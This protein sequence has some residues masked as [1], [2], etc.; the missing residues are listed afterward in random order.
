M[1][2]G[3][4]LR[5]LKVLFVDD[6]KNI[7]SSL[8]RL[9]VDEEFET[10]TASSG[11]EGLELLRAEENIG[12]VVSDQRMP[13]M[14]GAE[15]L[16]EVR[17]LCPDIPR[18]V[19][20][21]YADIDAAMDAINKGGACR[22]IKKPWD[23]DELLQ[24]LR[25]E[26]QRYRLLLENRQLQEVIRQKNEE[27][28][29]WNRNLKKRVLEQT[30]EIRVRNEQLHEQN[31]ELQRTLHGTIE[32]LSTLVELRDR[33]SAGHSVNVAHVSEAIAR[34]LGL[35]EEDVQ[36]IVEAA[37]LHDIGKIGIP[38]RL[39]GQ[40]PDEMT[41][42]DRAAY[43]KHAILGQLA[44]DKIVRLRP[45]GELVRHHHEWYDGSGYP[46]RL[47]GER[48][49]LGARIIA[50]ADYADHNLGKKADLDNIK[51]VLLRIEEQC[52]DRFD[53]YL[54]PHLRQPVI[55]LYGKLVCAGDK[56]GAILEPRELRVG[57]VLAENLY[58]GTGLM[59]L[60][61]GTVLEKKHLDSIMRYHMIDPFPGGVTVLVDRLEQSAAMDAD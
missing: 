53:P 40:D 25:G 2:D 42:D 29:E 32:A 54:F 34:G 19:L 44:I 13:E 18:I 11:A 61:E 49:P 57:M 35:G 38:G 16:A 9:T 27:L 23:N 55:E 51:K 26:L 58:S 30:R 22:Y 36:I 17:R 47:A 56:V 43:L 14:T 12:L 48:I 59:L 8:R 3:V 21:G 41:G 4:E 60:K 52:G 10:L 33:S 1:S 37:L 7:L 31:A 45:A 50:L 6:E 5:D 15:F 39:L 46:D 28:A 24:V 20:T